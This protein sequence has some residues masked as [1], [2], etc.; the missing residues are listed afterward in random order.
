MSFKVNERTPIKL[1]AP[2]YVS[3]DLFRPF[4]KPEIVLSVKNCFATDQAQPSVETENW[5]SLISGMWVT[6]NFIF[7][8]YFQK[9]IL[10]KFL[11]LIEVPNTFLNHKHHKFHPGVP[12][13]ND[14]G[15]EFSYLKIF[16]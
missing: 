7:K 4:D 10:I 8:L 3:M 15:Q 6:V 14:A 13:Q 9:I 1:N 11:K 2:V 5:Y 12:L 16:I